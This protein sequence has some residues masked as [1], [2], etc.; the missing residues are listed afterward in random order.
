MFT[1]YTADANKMLYLPS[2]INEVM[3]KLSWRKPMHLEIDFDY[4]DYE[5]FLKKIVTLMFDF[6]IIR[7][8]EVFSNPNY[9]EKFAAQLEP[10]NENRN[11]V[12]EKDF[13]YKIRNDDKKHQFFMQFFNSVQF[14]SVKMMRTYYSGEFSTFW[15]DL[16]MHYEHDKSTFIRL[17]NTDEN[18]PYQNVL[19]AQ[20]FNYMFSEYPFDQFNGL[21][22]S[23]T[24][25][26]NTDRVTK[27]FEFRITQVQDFFQKAFDLV[28]EDL[29]QFNTES[30]FP[31]VNFATNDM[32]NT[33]FDIYGQTYFPRMRSTYRSIFRTILQENPA[34]KSNNI[35]DLLSK[36]DTEV[37]RRYLVILGYVMFDEALDRPN[38]KYIKQ[39]VFK[40]KNRLALV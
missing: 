17:L 3:R 13:I 36:S 31:V 37:F 1:T 21:L 14:L 24:E 12:V 8:E 2:Q 22:D 18:F 40:K 6:M 38:V 15:N 10:H 33:F 32:L 35:T 20:N 30:D 11:K 23:K 19:T 39:D 25:A 27:Y 34:L 16:F 4:S 9:Q 28:K 5:K 29:S 7:N 26:N